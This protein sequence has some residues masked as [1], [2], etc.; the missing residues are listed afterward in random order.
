MPSD[1]SSPSTAS[2]S[3][4]LPSIV[5]VADAL[6]HAIE[7]ERAGRPSE[8]Q[9]DRAHLESLGVLGKLDGWIDQARELWDRESG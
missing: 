7:N 6:V 5:H 4:D 8:L 1:A 2:S 3:F 9:V